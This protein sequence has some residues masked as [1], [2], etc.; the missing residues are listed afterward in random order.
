MTVSGFLILLSHPK[1]QLL[2]EEAPKRSFFFFYFLMQAL[3]AFTNDH[4]N[5]VYLREKAP[6]FFSLFA[7]SLSAFALIK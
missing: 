3:Q 6:F 4:N 7:P 2:T 1:H 5:S